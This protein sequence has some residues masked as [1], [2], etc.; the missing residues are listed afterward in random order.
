MSMKEDLHDDL[1][2][3]GESIHDSNY[4][5]VWTGYAGVLFGLALVA[6]MFAVADGFS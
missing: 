1:E 2:S 5:G 6:F 4:Y 3:E